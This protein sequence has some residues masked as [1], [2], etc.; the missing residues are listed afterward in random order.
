MDG[1]RP[2]LAMTR[3]MT[4]VTISVTT[5]AERHATTARPRRHVKGPMMGTVRPLRATCVMMRVMPRVRNLVTRH[6]MDR[7][8]A[9]MTIR[10][11]T[12][13][14]TRRTSTPFHLPL[15]TPN[16]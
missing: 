13:A 16:N 15:R 6:M 10:R 3:A 9:A 2:R 5:L 14:P 12:R 8:T 11:T 7:L 1:T 4:R